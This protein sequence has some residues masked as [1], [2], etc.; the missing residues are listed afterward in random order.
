MNPPRAPAFEGILSWPRSFGAHYCGCLFIHAPAGWA[1]PVRRSQLPTPPSCPSSAPRAP[2]KGE[3]RR[4][5][6]RLSQELSTKAPEMETEGPSCPAARP[7][8]LAS[9]APCHGDV[10]QG[11]WGLSPPGRAH[12]QTV[13]CR[14]GGALTDGAPQQSS[15][16]PLFA[17]PSRFRAPWLFACPPV[18]R[19]MAG[20]GSSTFHEAPHVLI[21][22]SRHSPPI[23][24]VTRNP[25]QHGTRA[26]GRTL[27]HHPFPPP[28][29]LARS[30]APRSVFV[31]RFLR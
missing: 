18:P 26:C 4:Q 3:V 10:R 2:G 27:G 28:P 6:A 7:A 11:L 24:T 22:C 15:L 31:G 20:L 25:A 30:E 9:R 12:R 5:V 17:T 13:G 19:S 23:R 14:D 16:F 21:L 8:S 29:G 1:S